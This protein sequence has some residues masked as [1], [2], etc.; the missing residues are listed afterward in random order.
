MLLESASVARGGATMTS[1]FVAAVTLLAVVATGAATV[2][3]AWK[4]SNLA[5]ATDKMAKASVYGT[6]LQQEELAG[7]VQPLLTSVPLQAYPSGQSYSVEFADGFVEQLHDLGV[8]VVP[9]RPDHGGFC[10]VP[11]RNVG[12]GVAFLRLGFSWTA[13]AVLALVRRL[14][15]VR[16]GAAPAIVR[17]RGGVRLAGAGSGVVCVTTGWQAAPRRRLVP[18]RELRRVATRSWERKFWERKFFQT[19]FAVLTIRLV[20][21]RIMACKMSQ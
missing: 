17:G 4:T 12:G 18:A 6:D 10:S 11:L 2:F 13:H 5:E 20:G 8:I 14:C 21:D 9:R 19:V 1:D 15:G 16:V 7:S 3:L